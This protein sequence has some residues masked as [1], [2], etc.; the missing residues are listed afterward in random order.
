MLDQN[1]E[2]DTFWSLSNLLRTDPHNATFLE[3]REALLEQT[4]SCAKKA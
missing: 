1:Y 4:G 2:S 3:Q